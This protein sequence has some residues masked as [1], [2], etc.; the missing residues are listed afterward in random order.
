[1]SKIILNS[2][3]NVEQEIE[4]YDLIID[5]RLSNIEISK[6]INR[7]VYDIMEKRV[8]ILSNVLKYNDTH[9]LKKISTY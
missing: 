9:A 7:T 8:K 1:M 4:I 2:K 3:W 6:K 5:K